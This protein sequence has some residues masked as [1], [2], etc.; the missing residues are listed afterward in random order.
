VKRAFQVSVVVLAILAVG[1]CTTFQ[2]SGIQVVEDM[3]GMQPIGDFEIK[4]GVH[5]F[6][7]APGGAN[8]LNVTADSMDNEIYDAI[9]REVEKRS[10][11]AAINVTVTYE[12]SFVN[13]LLNAVTLGIYAPATAVITGTVVSYN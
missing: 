12:A 3:P 9:R 13:I 6:L 2:L 4:V 11:D 7:G 10:G 1:A 5:E 8:F